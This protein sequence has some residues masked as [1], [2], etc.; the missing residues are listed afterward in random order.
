[1]IRRLIT[2]AFP[3]RLFGAALL[4]LSLLAAVHAA[5]AQ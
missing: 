2:A 4:S 1:M 5:P 3:L